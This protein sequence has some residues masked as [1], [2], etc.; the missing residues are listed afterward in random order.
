MAGAVPYAR[1]FKHSLLRRKGFGKK[2]P[3]RP[4]EPGRVG[5]NASK[6]SVDLGFGLACFSRHFA[7]DHVHTLHRGRHTS[8]YFALMF[9]TYGPS[10]PKPGSRITG[11]Q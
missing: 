6:D 5:M 10:L 8:T 9:Q 1:Q 2:T 3:T 11:D 7:P 4:G